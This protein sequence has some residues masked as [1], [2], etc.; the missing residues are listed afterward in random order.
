MHERHHFLRERLERETLLT[1]AVEAALEQPWR[2]SNIYVQ[3]VFFVLTCIALAAFYLL[4]NESGLLTGIVALAAAEYL[5]RR[6]RWFFTGVEA[7]LWL[8]GLFALISELPRT[9]TPE[10]ILVIA[11]ACAIAGARVR[12]PLFGA[13]AAVLVA[14]YAEERADLG[15]LASLA[16][17]SLALLALLRTWRRPSTEWLFVAIA[18]I[19]PFA[20]RRFASE[21]WRD[22]TIVL[23]AAYGALALYLALRIRHHACFLAAILGFG[24]AGAVLAE[25]LELI[26][27]EARLALAGAFLLAIAF[28]V[29]RALRDRTEG[30]VLAPA[31]L[32][33]VDREL[34]LAATFSMKPETPHIETEKSGGGAFGGAGASGE[35]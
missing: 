7:G 27:L 31:T 34:E 16:I 6:R 26:P 24:V 23:Y 21:E 33:P 10:S 12:N 18:L 2:T 25:K 17:A 19:L 9:H 35:F 4:S 30:F 28:A 13:A 8:G 15:V 11:A 32:T 5:I 3:A 20:G 1:P 14:G 22:V 29:N